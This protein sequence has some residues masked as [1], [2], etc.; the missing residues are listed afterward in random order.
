MTFHF[1]RENPARA[2]SAANQ[3]MTTGRLFHCMI[4]AVMTEQDRS[5][6]LL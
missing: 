5:T 6:V 4:S 1:Y 3:L 2:V